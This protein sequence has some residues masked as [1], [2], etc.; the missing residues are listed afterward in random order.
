MLPEL[1]E[2]LSCPI[3]RGKAKPTYLFGSQDPII[4]NFNQHDFIPIGYR[5]WF[6]GISFIKF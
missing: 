5:D 3:Q 2:S 1:Q 4:G 6:W